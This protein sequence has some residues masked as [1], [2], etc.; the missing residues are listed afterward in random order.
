MDEV[1]Q[2][3]ESPTKDY[4]L[5]VSLYKKYGKNKALARTFERGSERFWLSKLTY[6]I[7]KLTGTA[8]A[9]KSSIRASSSNKEEPIPELIMACKKEISSLYSI[10]GRMHSDLYEIGTSNNDEAIKQRKAI[11]DKRKDIIIRADKLFLL[12]EDWF[13]GNKAVLDEIKSLLTMP[14]D[15]QPSLELNV[16]SFDNI[17]SMTDIQLVKRKSQLRSYITKTKNMLDFQSI[18]KGDSPTPMP[19]G[20][21][22]KSFEKRLGDLKKEYSIVLT[23]LDKRNAKCQNP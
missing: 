3:L 9:P 22:R 11:L 20:P 1:K 13:A 23:E 2:W 12:K 7:G 19:E 6:E 8:S 17:H 5:G 15:N 4:K 21:K 14:L 16:S 10:I 18:R